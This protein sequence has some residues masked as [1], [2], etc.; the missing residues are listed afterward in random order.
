MFQKAPRVRKHSPGRTEQGNADPVSKRNL[1]AMSAWD[2][3]PERISSIR[4]GV[5]K[6]L[7]IRENV[8]ILNA[9]R[10]RVVSHVARNSSLNPVVLRRY[11]KRPGCDLGV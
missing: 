7:Q 8:E 9:V 5:Y 3:T 4:I 11:D 6:F 2:N 1:D 10:R